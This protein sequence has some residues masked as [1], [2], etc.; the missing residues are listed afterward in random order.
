MAVKF[1]KEIAVLYNYRQTQLLTVVLC[2]EVRHVVT[3][4]VSN[5]EDYFSGLHPFNY[6]HKYQLHKHMINIKDDKGLTELTRN[7][8]EKNN[9]SS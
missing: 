8:F 2:G 4:R 3:N 9:V 5:K 6:T 7:V 1:T